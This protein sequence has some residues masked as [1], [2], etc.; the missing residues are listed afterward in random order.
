MKQNK[1][2]FKL[3]LISGLALII[4]CVTAKSNKSDYAKVIPTAHRSLEMTQDSTF[5]FF[6][7]EED[8]VFIGKKFPPEGFKIDEVLM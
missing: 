2:V 8:T 3:S 5:I 1:I 4:G 6:S 7:L